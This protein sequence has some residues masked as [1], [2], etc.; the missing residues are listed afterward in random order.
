MPSTKYSFVG[1][2]FVDREEQEL[3][4]SEFS[5]EDRV[6]HLEP[7]EGA[8]LNPPHRIGSGAQYSAGP[9]P[10]LFSSGRECQV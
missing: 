6:L 7:E 4:F 8:E 5:E 2:F 1:G 9:D 3:G 10:S